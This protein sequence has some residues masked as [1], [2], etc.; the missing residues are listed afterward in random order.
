MLQKGDQQQITIGSICAMATV[1]QVEPYQDKGVTGAFVIFDVPGYGETQ[2]FWYDEKTSYAQMRRSRSGMPKEYT[3]KRGKDFNWDYYQDDTGPQKNIANAFISRYE[4]FRRS[5]RGLYI[6]SATKGS[7][8][9][10]LACC[11]ANEVMERYN[12]V[13][14]FV[15][16]LDYIDLIKR[17]DE[18]ADMER[19]SLKRCGLLILDDVGVQTE[20]Q[21][22]INNAIFSLI[23]E[24]YR[25]LLPT[26]YTSN[27]PIE[28]ASGDDRIQSRIYGTSIPMLLPEISVRDQLADKYRDEFLRTVLN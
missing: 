6:Y 27:V 2:P 19:H 3:Y 7:G 18:D 16:V 1:K 20:K 25:N 13:V 17:K 28:K 10:L 9:T 5:G 8:K 23:D 4:E 11:L 14:K 12:A 24:R 15:Q 26:L 22:W 21:E